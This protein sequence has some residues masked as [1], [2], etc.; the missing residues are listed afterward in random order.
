MILSFLE[1]SRKLNK[2][3]DKDSILEIAEAA[4][5]AIQDRDN[6]GIL[7]EDLPEVIHKLEV[8]MNSAAKQLDFEEAAKLRD[9]I[10]RL[11]RKMIGKV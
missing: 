3:G 1:L 5:D 10:K 9:R 6:I 8:K 7:L 2:D 4:T 11:R